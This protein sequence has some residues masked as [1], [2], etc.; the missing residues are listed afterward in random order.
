MT[1]LH[2]NESSIRI[3]SLDLLIEIMRKQRRCIAISTLILIIAYS[4]TKCSAVGFDVRV[5]SYV[6]HIRASYRVAMQVVRSC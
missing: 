4:I 2:I 3:G 5:L 6:Q 1:L